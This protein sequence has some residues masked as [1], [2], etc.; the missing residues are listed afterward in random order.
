MHLQQAIDQLEPHCDGFHIDVMDNHFV[1]NLTWGAQF[2]NAFTHASKK[3]LFVHLMVTKPED[4]LQ[5]LSLRTFDSFCFHI[6]TTN[7]PKKL[8]KYIREKKWRPAI[9]LKPNTP[10]DEL[11]SC[12]S[13]IDQVLLMSVNPGFSGQH[14]LPDSL[15][16]LETLVRFKKEHNLNFSI[17]MDGGIN[18]SNIGALKK[19]GATEFGIASAIF[20]AHNPISMLEKLKAL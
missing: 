6:E 3:P 18:E 14:F 4:F 5:T 11:F 15:E 7:N 2:V 16:R 19:R 12:L 10:I 17:V 1:P 8:I 13:M 9:T 20:D